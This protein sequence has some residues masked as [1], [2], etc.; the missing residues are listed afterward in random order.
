[1]AWSGQD[2]CCEH[3]RRKGSCKD[4]GPG[5]CEHKSRRGSCKEC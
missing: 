1:M 3:E 4:C 5:Y 2:S